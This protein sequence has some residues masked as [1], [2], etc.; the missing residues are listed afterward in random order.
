MCIGKLLISNMNKWFERLISIPKTVWVNF[1]YLPFCEA[2]KIPFFVSWDTS[3]SVRKKGGVKF[4]CSIRTGMVHLGFFKIKMCEPKAKTVFDI[5]GSLVIKGDIHAGNGTKIRVFESGKMVLG[6]DFK[7]S[8][9]SAFNCFHQMIFGNNIQFAW[10]CMVMDGDGHTI[11]DEKGEE[12]PAGKPVVFGNNIWI[13]CRSTILKGSVIPDNC[14]IGSMSL[15]T[16][17]KFEEKTIIAGNP[18]K[19]IKKI[20]GWRL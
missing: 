7:V 19:S 14:V 1:R 10:D 17:D 18:A 3:F 8:S 11:Y 20:G 12:L 9:S 15:V 5:Q 2:I 16:G 4:D 6:N 13:G